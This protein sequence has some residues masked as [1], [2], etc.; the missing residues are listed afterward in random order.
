MQLRNINPH[1]RKA[2]VCKLIT[3]FNLIKFYLIWDI[4]KNNFI[5]GCLSYCVVIKFVTIESP[6]FYQIVSNERNKNDN[7]SGDI[8][9][10]SPNSPLLTSAQYTKLLSAPIKRQKNKHEDDLLICEGLVSMEANTRFNNDKDIIIVIPLNTLNITSLSILFVLILFGSYY[11]WK[12]L[13][14][15]KCH[16]KICKG[17]YKVMDKLSEGGFGEVSV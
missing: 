7:I 3:Y 5:L 10:L 8:R 16:C 11:I 17:E 12:V 1:K 6:C 14:R 4:L 2:F 13:T 9:V 15:E